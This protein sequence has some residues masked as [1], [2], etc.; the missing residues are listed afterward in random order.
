MFQDSFQHRGLCAEMQEFW[1][2]S[3]I[4]GSWFC[5]LRGFAF[6][7]RR[8]GTRR[9]HF[10]HKFCAPD[11]APLATEQGA[12]SL[13]IGAAFEIML[14][15]PQNRAHNREHNLPDAVNF[16]CQFQILGPPNFGQPEILSLTIALAERGEVMMRK[17][18]W[19]LFI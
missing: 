2:K 15:W 7:G 6:R 13:V 12:F 5:A 1:G 14:P 11:S 17:S 19:A 18:W 3:A 9:S 16:S 10:C 8:K 4:S